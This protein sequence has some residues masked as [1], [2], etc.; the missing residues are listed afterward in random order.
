MQEQQQKQ[1]GQ[2]KK[3]PRP[4]EKW[5][6]RIAKALEK[7]GRL[8]Q[9]ADTA[10]P[11]EEQDPS[12]T[13]YRTSLPEQQVREPTSQDKFHHLAFSQIRTAALLSN[14]S[15]KTF[16]ARTSS[17]RM[18]NQVLRQGKHCDDVVFRPRCCDGARGQAPP[19]RME[20]LIQ[21]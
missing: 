11:I 7:C 9:L 18:A 10:I 6:K 14:H 4:G 12:P 8:Q 17:E 19:K 2:K 15:E 5:E 3:R 1:Q 13:I 21:G 20:N 16:S